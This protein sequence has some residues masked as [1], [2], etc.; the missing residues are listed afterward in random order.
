MSQIQDPQTYIALV[1][2]KLKLS[3]YRGLCYTD[4]I[5][6][7]IARLERKILKLEAI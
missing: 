6:K 1:E 5:E 7:K 4:G 2:A 3:A